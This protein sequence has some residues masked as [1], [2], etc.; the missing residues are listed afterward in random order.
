MPSPG[1]EEYAEADWT[2]MLFLNQMF[3]MEILTAEAT[4]IG[5]ETA[6]LGSE[7]DSWFCCLLESFYEIPFTVP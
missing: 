7:S 3:Q 1:R 5:G 6:G 4:E 2:G